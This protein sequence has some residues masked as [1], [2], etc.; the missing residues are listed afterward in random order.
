MS[1]NMSNNRKNG[2]N[3]LYAI[4]FFLLL[5][6]LT[7]VSFIIPLRPTV[8]NMEKRELATFPEFTLEALLSGDYFD[9]ITLWFSDTFPGREGWIQI[10]T[11]TKSLYGYSEISIQGDLGMTDVIPEE[12]NAVSIQVTEGSL[13]TEANGAISEEPEMETTS[14][15]EAPT[16]WGGVNAEE[17]EVSN[18]A[19]VQIGDSAFNTLGFSK[20]YSDAYVNLINRFSDCVKNSDVRVISCIAPTAIGILVEPEYLSLFNSYSQADMLNY[21]HSN[22]NDEIVKVDTVSALL[23]HNDEYLFFRTDHHWTA[24]G[25]YYSYCAMCEATGMEAAPLDSFRE[26]NQGDFKGSIYYQVKYPNK[27]KMDT[28]YAYVPD[29]DI[30][31]TH[32]SNGYYFTETELIA[33]RTTWDPNCRYLCFISGGTAITKLV[34]HDLPDAPNCVVVIDSFGNCFVPFLTQN[35]HTIYAIDYRKYRAMDLQR[36]CQQNDID[37]V[38]VAPYMMATQSSLVEPLFQPLYGV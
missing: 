18:S 25:A 22:M 31:A 21:L 34:N 36:F 7:V 16:E 14:A 9:G 1:D 11:D 6:I 32:S 5:A 33:D 15:A 10:A 27:L 17:Y 2:P 12:T 28:V 20:I 4:P 24:L 30:E 8:S 3:R 29:D 23:E 19:I 13:H 35:Y 37:D 38:I 26:W